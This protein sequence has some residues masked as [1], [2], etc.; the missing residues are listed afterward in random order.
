M[1]LPV[2]FNNL[3]QQIACQKKE[4]REN[5]FLFLLRGGIQGVS[6][7]RVKNKF[8]HFCLNLTKRGKKKGRT[9]AIKHYSY[10]LS[11]HASI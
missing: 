5:I 2:S 1:H 7:F 11:H 4:P 9:N 6:P 3:N 8:F 10:A